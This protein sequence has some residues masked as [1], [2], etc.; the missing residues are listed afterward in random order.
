MIVKIVSAQAC[1][2]MHQFGRV[3]IQS[4]VETAT[5]THNCFH[6]ID[7]ILGHRSDSKDRFWVQRIQLRDICFRFL[8]ETTTFQI[9]CIIC[10]MLLVLCTA[11]IKRSN[12]FNEESNTR[13]IN[14]TLVKRRNRTVGKA[15][16]VVKTTAAAFGKPVTTTGVESMGSPSSLVSKRH[17]CKVRVV[18]RVFG[19]CVCVVFKSI[20]E[21]LGIRHFTSTA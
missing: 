1:L 18:R 14:G 11:G 16:A 10:V 2:L 19:C 20:T 8:E 21:A 4:H 7:G 15:M 17:L 13:T 5:I 3:C 9:I 6:T 12:F